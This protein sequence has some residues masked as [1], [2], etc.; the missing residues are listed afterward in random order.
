VR[1]QAVVSIEGNLSADD[2]YFTRRRVY[3]WS[4][5]TTSPASQA[6]LRQHANSNQD[7]V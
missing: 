6:F 5:L 3:L 7:S 2:A 1:C 4:R